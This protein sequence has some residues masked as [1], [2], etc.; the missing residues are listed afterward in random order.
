MIHRGAPRGL[1]FAKLYGDGTTEPPQARSFV[2]ASDLEKIKGKC[3]E[4]I[5]EKIK[6]K[7]RARAIVVP[8]QFANDEYYPRC[9]VGAVDFEAPGN[10]AVEFRMDSL[11]SAVIEDRSQQAAGNVREM[12]RLDLQKAEIARKKEDMRR[13]SS[14]VE[15]SRVKTGRAQCC[16]WRIANG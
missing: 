8:L 11:L 13:Q 4:K 14:R 7:A 15:P 1:W 12:A 3:A 2:R 6:E 5:K 10:V 9:D 16:R